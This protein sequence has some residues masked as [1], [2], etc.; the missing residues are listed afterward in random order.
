[1]D[2]RALRQ[3]ATGFI[4]AVLIAIGIVFGA[5]M[6]VHA[7]H[8]AARADAAEH[9]LAK[10]Q[11]SLELTQNALGK[12]GTA[13]H[14]TQDRL[15]TTSQALSRTSSERTV[16][17]QQSRNCRYLVRVNDH[18]LWGMTNYDSATGFLMDGRRTRAAASIKFASAHVKAI[19]VL[20]KR[21]GHK[22]ISDL[23][24]AC[25]PPVAH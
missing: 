16:L 24:N 18:L 19:D 12:T 15:T 3:I 1:M 23:V 2:H 10:T 21:S 14:T 20:V 5:T 8:E 4:I 6:F 11:L 17:A 13:L 7:R 9:K 22:T 25:A